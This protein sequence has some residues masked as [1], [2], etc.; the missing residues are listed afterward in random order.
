MGIPAATEI[1][2]CCNIRPHITSIVFI[3]AR[4]DKKKKK[5]NTDLMDNIN[6]PVVGL[7]WKYFVFRC[8]L[9]LFHSIITLSVSL[10]RLTCDIFVK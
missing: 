5:K 6:K 3:Q 1:M 9:P 10:R 4:R 8:M 2:R 7:L